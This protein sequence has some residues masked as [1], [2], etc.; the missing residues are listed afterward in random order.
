MRMRFS[1]RAV[2]A[3]TAG[4]L[5]LSLVNV[6][7]ASAAPGVVIQENGSQ[8]TQTRDPKAGQCYPGLGADIAVANR[9]GG[10]I[11]LFPDGN[12]QTKILNPLGPGEFRPDEHV[13]SFLALD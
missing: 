10:T 12:C 6:S 8:F 11:L 5:A 9:T 1:P 13:G 4:V 2:L 3:V 7:T